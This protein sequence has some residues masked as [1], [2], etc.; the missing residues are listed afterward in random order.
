MQKEKWA[1]EGNTGKPDFSSGS[2]PA[3]INM[4]ME[5]VLNC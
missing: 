1:Q 4:S 5:K 2:P 3:E